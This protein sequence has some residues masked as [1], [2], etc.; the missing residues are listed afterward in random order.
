MFLLC[1]VALICFD[2]SM[3][4]SHIDSCVS[5]NWRDLVITDY[6][7]SILQWA[8]F[9]SSDCSITQIK[10]SKT[11]QKGVTEPKTKLI[12]P[13]QSSDLNPV[14]HEWTEEKKHRH[15][16]VNI[17]DLEWFWMKEWSLISCQVFSDLNPVEDEWTEEK[18]HRHGSV[19][20]KGLEWFW[21]KEWSLISCQVFS[22]LN[23]VEHEWTEEKKHR[24]GSVNLKGLEW[25][26]I[27]EWS[28]IWIKGCR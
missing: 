11:T 1:S 16:S 2:F 24:H 3:R 28:L 18:K 21:M 22:D 15:G 13:F 10:T 8:M 26:W 23:P 5:F 25:F 9:W 6:P 12:W 20:L 7:L 27:K 4:F 14:E 17:K 19:N